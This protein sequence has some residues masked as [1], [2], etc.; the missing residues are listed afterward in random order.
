MKTNGNHLVCVFDTL[1]VHTRIDCRLA[2]EEEKYQRS[3]Q[4]TAY[5]AKHLSRQETK[6]GEARRG[7]FEPE[8]R[9]ISQRRGNTTV[10]ST[11]YTRQSSHIRYYAVQACTTCVHSP[12]GR[13]NAELLI[14]DSSPY[15][16]LAHDAISC[17]SPLLHT[18]HHRPRLII[19]QQ[20]PGH[21]HARVPR[22][23][24][25]RIAPLFFYSHRILLRMNLVECKKQKE[26]ETPFVQE[27]TYCSTPP[28]SPDS[29]LENGRVSVWKHSSGFRE[30]G[31]QRLHN[32]KRFRD[33][34]RV[35]R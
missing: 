33:Q 31:L 8:S 28:T 19:T 35:K 7:G 5:I 21:R 12:I 4:H 14:S 13:Q 34:L 9:G 25:H 2:E 18:T 20:K 23:N 10:N 24:L 15:L 22:S 29:L 27:N 17:C 16:P 1:F 6:F 30:C 32:D 3:D 26:I 11:D